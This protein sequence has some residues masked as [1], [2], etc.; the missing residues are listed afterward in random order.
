MPQRKRPAPQR[1]SAIVIPMRTIFCS[2]H[3]WPRGGIAAQ[4][5]GVPTLVVEADRLP[6]GPPA[7]LALSGD[8]G[9]ALAVSCWAWVLAD[10]FSYLT[11]GGKGGGW[12]LQ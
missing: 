3:A 7:E 12:G 2:G 9:N 8:G 4:V 10:R 5:I 1:A 6:A 11:D